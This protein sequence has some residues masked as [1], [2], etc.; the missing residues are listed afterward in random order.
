MDIRVSETFKKIQD[1]TIDPELEELIPPLSEEEY[2][3][4]ENSI[5]TYGYNKK[6]PI[7]VW[8]GIIIDGHHR[9]KICK[10]NDIGFPV[11]EMNFDSRS[12]VIV[13]MIDNQKNKRNANKMTLNYLIGKQYRESKKSHGGDRKSSPQIEDLKTTQKIAKSTGVSHATVERAAVFSENL[14][15]ICENAGIKRQEILLGNI[16]TTIK[17][18]N[19]LASYE[20]EF[21]KRAIEKT[22]NNE[23]KDIKDAIS[24][25]DKEFREERA[26]QLREEENK[27]K[28]EEEKQA[29]EEQRLEE[30][31]K[32]IELE[33]KLAEEE[34][35]RIVCKNGIWYKLGEHL[36]YCG[37]N[38]DEAFK[39]VLKEHPASFAFADPP[40]NADVAEWDSDFIWAQ[41]WLIDY[42][43]IIAVTPGIVSIHHFMNNTKMPYKWSIACWLDNGMTRGALGFGNWI[44]TALFSNESV[45]RNSQDILRFSIDTSESEDTAHKGRKPYQLIDWLIHHYSKKN[46]YIIDPFLGSG[47]TLLVAQKTDRKCIGA[48][49]VPEFCNEIIKRWESMAGKKAVIYEN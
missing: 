5:L 36:L 47:T 33:L 30:E 39:S 17:D 11:E 9:Y 40:Y 28:E 32:R 27:R 42:A 41:D 13:W 34:R 26:Q 23:A 3:G 22:L 14:E 1:L 44:Y 16:K 19:D 37:S 31:R 29:A 43:K 15:N 2:F 12:D 38:E 8:N 10:E 21:H 46:D 18:I 49:V 24:K 7:T 35:N 48:E 20:P 4:L 25:T 45:F 6:Y